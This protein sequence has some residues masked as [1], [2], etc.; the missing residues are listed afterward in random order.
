MDYGVSRGI[1]CAVA[2]AAT[3]HESAIDADSGQPGGETR[4]QFELVQV[5][6]SYGYQFLK[7]IS[8][9]FPTLGDSIDCTEGAP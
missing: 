4:V 2:P 5:K 8:G 3:P 9:V 6:Q 7:H 1:L